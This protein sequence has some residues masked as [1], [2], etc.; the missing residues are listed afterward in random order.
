MPGLSQLKK[1]SQ[2]LL[3]IGDEVI[4]RSSRGEKPVRV[5]IPKDIV[6][7]DDSEEFMLGMPEIA[8]EVESE[9]IDDDLS[10]LM[11][12]S[13]PASDKNDESESVPSFE[14]PDMSSILNPVILDGDGSDVQMP[15]LSMFEDSPAEEIEEEEIEA[16]PE[17]I[18]IADMGLDALLAGSGF[19]GSE[20]KAE[21]ESNSDDSDDFYNFDDSDAPSYNGSR[22]IPF[23]DSIISEPYSFKHEVYRFFSPLFENQK[24]IKEILLCLASS[25]YY[26][27]IE[28]LSLL[29]KAK[30]NLFD[31]KNTNINSIFYEYD[32][33]FTEPLILINDDGIIIKKHFSD[34]ESLL[35]L[36]LGRL[37]YSDTKI[38][39]CPGCK[40]IYVAKDKR[41][42]YCS[43][44]CKNDVNSKNKNNNIFY[45][46]YRKR[47][48]T[49][50]SNY[51][52]K[53]TNS[54][55]TVLPKR[56][57]IELSSLLTQY[58]NKDENNSEIIKEYK[59]KLRAIK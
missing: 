59:E 15:D 11:G 53:K 37:L 35:L 22:A 13:K 30:P 58:T 8:S 20:G 1:F 54:S 17:E 16:E 57:K 24:K 9:V 31:F 48:R 49:L 18:S 4:I 32:Y 26:N 41:Q 28:K 44:K 2:N 5:K 42:K 25:D 55:D 56:I 21:S 29:Y 19:D 43:N 51:S 34:V 23:P 27:K 46:L 50:H 6:D 45:E 12:L 52:V 10:D 47:Y 38:I 33:L 3:S 36:E 14:A 39:F 7:A 40:E